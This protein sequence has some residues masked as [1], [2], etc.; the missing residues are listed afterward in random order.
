MTFCGAGEGVDDV[1]VSRWSGSGWETPVTISSKDQWP[2]ILPVLTLDDNGQPVISWQ[3]FNGEQYVQYQSHWDGSGWSAEA[4]DREDPKQLVLKKSLAV[5]Q[6]EEYSKELPAFLQD[7]SQ[8]V[9]HS[10]FGQR[11]TVNLRTR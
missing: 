10:T 1:F 2:D 8:A 9:F 11:K 5:Q 4:E 3:G 7:R 6:V